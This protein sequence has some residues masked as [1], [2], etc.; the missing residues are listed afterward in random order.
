MRPKPTKTSTQAGLKPGALWAIAAVMLALLLAP[1][2]DAQNGPRPQTG[3][4]PN[5]QPQTGP[6]PNV[7]PRPQ[8]G[9]A[10]QPRPNVQPDA[11]PAA[12]NTPDVPEWVVPGARITQFGAVAQQEK[13]NPG[14]ESRWRE[15]EREAR[16]RDID[17]GLSADEVERRA[18]QREE[19][20]AADRRLFKVGTGGYSFTQ[21]DIIAV[22]DVGVL[23][24]SRIYALPPLGGAPEVNPMV[25]KRLVDHATGAGLWMSPATIEATEESRGEDGGLIVYKA[26]YTIGEHTFDAIMIVLTNGEYTRRQIYDRATGMQ[27]Y[28]SELTD[29]NLI[30]SHAYSEL[31][32]YRVAELPWLGTQFTEQVQGF[33]K[34]TYSGAMV[35]VADQLPPDLQQPGLGRIPDTRMELTAEFA[36]EAVTPELIGTAMT[37]RI[38]MPNGQDQNTEAEILHSPNAR[39]GLYIDPAVLNGLREGQVLDEDPAIGYTIRVTDVYQVQGTTLVEITEAGRNNSYTSVVTYDARVGLMV[40]SVTNT[41]SLSQRM[42]SQLQAVE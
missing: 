10:V 5:T 16:Q 7:Q 38:R 39:F 12:A 41:P 25:N 4:R 18:R 21:Y 19:N 34:L 29:T 6:R 8:T 26:P 24:E 40:A 42:E 35:F 28:Q 11:R 20:R 17:A 14:R 27:L 33:R 2:A 9:P 23:V 1:A 30:R 37:G 15:Q 13:K 32:G 31:T 36:Y 3:P 22:T